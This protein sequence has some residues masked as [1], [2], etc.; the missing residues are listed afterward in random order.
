M[1]KMK[2]KIII[3]IIL[4]SLISAESSSAFSLFGESIEENTDSITV[5]E[6]ITEFI[7]HTNG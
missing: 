7:N 2:T 5:G 4:L 6:P 3:L 1:T